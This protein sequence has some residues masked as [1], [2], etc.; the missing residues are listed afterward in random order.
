MITSHE[1]IRWWYNIFCR[2]PRG[3]SCSSKNYKTFYRGKMKFCNS[4]SITRFYNILRILGS[5]TFIWPI[6]S[7]NK[8][9]RIFVGV[10]YYICL[11]CHILVFIPSVIFTLRNINNTENFLPSIVGVVVF[12][13]VAWSVLYS[14]LKRNQYKVHDLCYWYVLHMD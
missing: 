14:R 3:K 5:I 12:V 10:T 6:S 9:F 1:C 7:N 11:I 4:L 13:E 2:V 8:F